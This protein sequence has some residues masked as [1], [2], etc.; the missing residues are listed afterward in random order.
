MLDAVETIKNCEQ[1]VS[2]CNELMDSLTSD[3]E[4]DELSEKQIAKYLNLTRIK[5]GALKARRSVMSKLFKWIEDSWDHDYWCILKHIVS[6]KWFMDEVN[7]ATDNMF[8]EEWS[9]LYK[10]MSLAL[11]QFI[12]EEPQTCARCMLDDL[13]SNDE[14]DDKE[15]PF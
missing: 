10:L 14:E 2:H 1:T 6:A 3:K 8:Y 12:W 15:S 9:E 11:S 5:T 4:I 7:D 13:L